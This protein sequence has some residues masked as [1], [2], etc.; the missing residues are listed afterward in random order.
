VPV[1][2]RIVLGSVTFILTLMMVGEWVSRTFPYKDDLWAGQN[3]QYRVSLIRYGRVPWVNGLAKFPGEV[4]LLDSQGRIL[5]SR[6]I[7]N[8]YSVRVIAWDREHVYYTYSDGANVLRSQLD[9][10]P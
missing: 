1:I 7:N 3:G 5:D 2:F 6:Q 9:I 10:E 4:R 8:V